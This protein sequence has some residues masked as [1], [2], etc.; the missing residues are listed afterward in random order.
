MN[1]KT[2]YLL[3]AVAGTIIPYAFFLQHFQSSG[4]NIIAF[5]RAVFANG[6]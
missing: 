5:A 4:F 3:L 2:V 6:A 1:M